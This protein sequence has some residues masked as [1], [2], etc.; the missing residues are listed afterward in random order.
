M[1][2]IDSIPYLKQLSPELQFVVLLLLAPVL[3]ILTSWLLRAFVMRLVIAPI[4]GLATRSNNT[5]DDS[6]IDVFERPLRLLLVGV[7]ITI[8]S[9]LFDFTGDI[10]GFADNLSR[11]LYLSAIV[12]FV[13]NL[14]NVVSLTSE[15]LSR[16]TGLQI[17]D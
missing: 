8:I 16:I 15:T 9:Y 17:Q 14:V 1:N 12:Y 10:D 6:A 3:I 4:R 2:L 7:A 13:Y 5:L 11:A